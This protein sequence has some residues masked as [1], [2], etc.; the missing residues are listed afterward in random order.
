MTVSGV[1]MYMYSLY[2]MSSLYNRQVY[3]S[4]VQSWLL[5]LLLMPAVFT[6][7]TVAMSQGESDRC[8]IGIRL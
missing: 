2:S 6:Q 5:L 1:Y 4:T 3:A 7:A 8:R